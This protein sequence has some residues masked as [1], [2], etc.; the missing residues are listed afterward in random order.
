MAFNFLKILGLKKTRDLVVQN[1]RRGFSFSSGIPVYEDN[2]M[3]VSAFYRGVIYISSQ[4]AKLPWE[5]K[6]KT[7]KIIDNN[8]SVLLNLC[9]NPE[10][11]SMFFR[12]CMTQNA[13]IH[14]NSYAEIERDLTGKPVA[15]WPIPSNFVQPT[16][17]VEGK[18]VYRIM[19][20]ATLSEWV[21][22]RPK[23]IFHVK[24]FHTKDGIVG[25][26]VVGYGT[27]VLGI[28]LG[29]DRMAGSLFQNGGMPSGV[30]TVT[31]TLSDEAFKR[32]KDSW[33]ESHG[34]RNAGGIAVLEEGADFKPTQLSPDIM[35]FLESRKFSVIEI[36]RF[37]G[38][39]PSKLFDSEKS[40]YNNQEQGALEVATDTL[41]A[42][43]RNYEM[44]A[45]IKLLNNQYGGYFTEMDLY[46]VFRG[47]MAT[48]AEYFTKMMGTG[49]IT[50]NEIRN[51]E[52]MAPYKN[53]DKHYI[54]VNNFSPADRVDDIIDA[55][56]A[57]KKTPQSGES[58]VPKTE[59][60]KNPKSELT[61]LEQAVKTYLE[62]K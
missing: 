46:A 56:I 26:G 10:M 32:V 28:S 52:G 4:M 27:D 57:S 19:G 58:I 36:A 17:D 49:S 33:K 59:P 7:N 5:I 60:I 45:D 43:A 54:A 11:S 38:V 51:K 35:Q 23:D 55:Q 42:W 16:R 47:D 29:A 22:L 1:P 9:P 61:E 25:L 6:D 18:L 40:S 31:G 41:D 62:K 39:P 20:S 12:L 24:N 21:Y 30:L 13:I 8:L 53:G 34:G 2:A 3:Q 15:L 50:P 48:R 14:G 44:E 37:L